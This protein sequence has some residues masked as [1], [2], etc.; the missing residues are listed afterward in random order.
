MDREEARE[1]LAREFDRHRAEEGEILEGYHALSDQLG[2]GPLGLLINH[3]ATEK[4][5]H[6]FLLGTLSD[7]LRAP[8]RPDEAVSDPRA[9][10][11]TLLSQTRM[12]RGH[13]KKTI[14]ACRSLQ[15]SLS[16]EEGAL[17]D[18]F[19]EAIATDSEKHQ[20][21]LATVEALIP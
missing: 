19:L 17:L 18:A 5:M 20:R 7:W 4:E 2:E 12:L 21:L 8:R 11:D 13:E 14:D 15:A 1:A 3:I 16:G 6:H 10:R 9:D